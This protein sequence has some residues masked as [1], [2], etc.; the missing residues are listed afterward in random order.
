[1]LVDYLSR[2]EL[3]KQKESVEINEIFPDE[4]MFNV[5]EGPWY[6]DRVSYLANF[7][8]PSDYSS[9]HRKKFFADM[10]YYFWK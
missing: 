6:A 5:K 2:L 1:M 10:K 4:Q 7:I 3:G 9:H 8:T